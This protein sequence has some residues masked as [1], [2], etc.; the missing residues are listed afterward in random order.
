MF[1]ERSRTAV[2]ALGL[3]CVSSPLPGEDRGDRTVE[4]V[5]Y[6]P[7]KFTGDG[8]VEIG[9]ARRGRAPPRFIPGNR[10]APRLA[11]RWYEITGPNEEV[12]FAG[13]LPDP[14]K[15]IKEF[16]SND[17]KLATGSEVDDP[18][19]V[20]TICVPVLQ[21]MKEIKF[22]RRNKD[23]HAA[24]LLGTPGPLGGP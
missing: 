19:S 6:I 1:S 7:L 23:S 13:K 11:P 9:A 8:N 22:Y 17:Q 16:T 24:E 4:A 3:L 2:I 15:V 10:T 21:N 5:M 12:L 18:D 20:L 14:R